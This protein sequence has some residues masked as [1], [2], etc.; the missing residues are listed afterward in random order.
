MA[1]SRSAP[2]LK[3]ASTFD[4]SGGR[5]CLD[6]TNTLSKRLTSHPRE[7]LVSYGDLVAWSRQA[8]VVTGLEAQGLIRKA[9][10]RPVDAAAV[11]DRAIALRE[12]IYRV[13]SAVAAER[14]ARGGDLAT[15]NAAL[16][17]AL[18]LLGIAPEGD[19]FGWAWTGD[20]QRLDRMLWPVTRSAADLLTSP[21]LAA[22]R[23]CEAESCAWLF[24]DRSRN[25]SRRWC[26]MK[27]CGNRAKARRHYERKRKDRKGT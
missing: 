24:M 12:A 10:R 17:E 4:L 5:V 6:F 11:L 25:R 15:L 2:A 18:P 19:G 23:E 27:A 14:P 21:E 9:R 8:G 20:G 22:V 16:A 7:L 1:R 26:D 3:A 13:F